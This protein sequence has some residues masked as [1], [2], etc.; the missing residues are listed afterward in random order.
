M[1][2]T[3][4]LLA[5]RKDT[6]LASRCLVRAAGVDR[7]S[8]TRASDYALHTTMLMALL[9]YAVATQVK[10]SLV[11]LVLLRLVKEPAEIVPQVPDILTILLLVDLLHLKMKHRSGPIHLDI[12]HLSLGVI[13]EVLILHIDLSLDVDAQIPKLAI[14]SCPL[15]IQID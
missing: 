2:V 1:E 13:L 6:M 3:D 9:D 12:Q 5:R 7:V 15:P 11:Y 8:D 10:A 14:C 4:E